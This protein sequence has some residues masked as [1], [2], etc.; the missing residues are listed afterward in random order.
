MSHCLFGFCFDLF[1]FHRDNYSLLAYIQSNL[2]SSGLKIKQRK[3]SVLLLLLF[4]T[5]ISNWLLWEPSFLAWLQFLRFVI[6]C[7]LTLLWQFLEIFLFKEHTCFPK[8]ISFWKLK[9]YGMKS[10]YHKPRLQKWRNFP[11]FHLPASIIAAQKYNYTFSWFVKG[12]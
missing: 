1:A 5:C 2:L 8:T 6:W 12:S 7:I 9:V 11:H 4:R 10:L 3:F